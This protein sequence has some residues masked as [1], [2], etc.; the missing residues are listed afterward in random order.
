MSDIA[1]RLALLK[2]N[3]CTCPD[4]RIQGKHEPDCP[5]DI[6]HEA[7]VDLRTLERENAKLRSVMLPI[8]S[9][10][11]AAGTIWLDTETVDRLPHVG[12]LLRLGYLRAAATALS[13]AK[14]RK[15]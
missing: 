10:A 5:T 8:A 1:N 7:C 14:E 15:E 4:I 11:M 2:M 9:V 6:I 3:S 12:V 13:D